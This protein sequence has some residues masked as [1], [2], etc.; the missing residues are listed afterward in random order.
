MNTKQK[1]FEIEK[2]Y[3]GIKKRY[4]SIG[5]IYDSV[6]GFWGYYPEN[7]KSS[8]A[9][10]HDWFLKLDFIQSTYVIASMLRDGVKDS[11]S[12]E[13][14]DV[15]L[16]NKGHFIY[17][18]DKYFCDYLA[19]LI[20]KQD[21]MFLD[22][23]YGPYSYNDEIDCQSDDEDTYE[24]ETKYFKKYQNGVE[25]E[26]IDK[27]YTW[28]DIHSNQYIEKERYSEFIHDLNYILSLFN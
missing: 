2:T 5:V 14:Q 24:Y 22:L 8:K 21:D 11:F 4:L 28:D 27:E 20:I 7:F 9:E 15:I 1:L 12:I 13:V 10:W 18:S 3:N 17:F 6:D 16:K 26:I 19:G 23:L 25:L